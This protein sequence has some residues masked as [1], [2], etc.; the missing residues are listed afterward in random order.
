MA[1]V[2]SLKIFFGRRLV[3]NETLTPNKGIF[4]G[5]II[6]LNDLNPNETWVT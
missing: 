1:K 5:F 3:K 6:R 4:I 2:F